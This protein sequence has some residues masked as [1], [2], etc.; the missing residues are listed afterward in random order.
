MRNPKTIKIRIAVAVDYA[1]NYAAG[2]WKGASADE[3]MEQAR[4]GLVNLDQYDGGHQRYWV[5]IEVPVPQATRFI[6]AVTVEAENLG[7]ENHSS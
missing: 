7:E 6:G 4:E 3:A 2:G 1:G 5:D